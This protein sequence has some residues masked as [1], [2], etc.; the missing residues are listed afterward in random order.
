MIAWGKDCNRRQRAGEAALQA[1]DLGLQWALS[2]TN[3]SL[4]WGDRKLF[5]RAVCR[6]D[7]ESDAAAAPAAPGRAQQDVGQCERLRSLTLCLAGRE[8]LP[9]LFEV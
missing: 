1:K 4:S 6:E 9:S 8:H 5:C 3:I 7:T 2:S